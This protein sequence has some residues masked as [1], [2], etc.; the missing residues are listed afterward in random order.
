MGRKKRLIPI[1]RA[2][3]ITAEELIIAELRKLNAPLWRKIAGLWNQDF[4]VRWYKAKEK[5]IENKMIRAGK[6]V[7]RSLK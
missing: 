1:R 6:N 7:Y 3:S 2:V 5:E 4:L